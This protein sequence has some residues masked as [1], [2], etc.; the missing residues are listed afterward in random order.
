[1][2]KAN[3]IIVFTV[4]VALVVSGGAFGQGSDGDGKPL[5]SFPETSYEFAP[6]PEGTVIHHDYLVKNKGTTDLEIQNVKAG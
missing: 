6:V 4:L 2:K 3:V 1:M 5:A